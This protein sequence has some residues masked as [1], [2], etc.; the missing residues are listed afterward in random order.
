MRQW[1]WVTV[2]L[3]LV[4][5][6][7]HTE[8]K[9]SQLVEQARA[10]AKSWQRDAILVEI[11]AT[12]GADG[13]LDLKAKGLPAHSATF[14]FFSPSTEQG[15]LVTFV[16][17]N[18]DSR[19]FPAGQYRLPIPDA[20]IDLSQ[21]VAGARK[22]GFHE[23]SMFG[24]SSVAADLTVHQTES[25]NRLAW[26]LGGSDQAGSA[27]QMW[28]DAGSGVVFTSYD[29]L[30]SGVSSAEAERRKAQ[31]E[32]RLLPQNTAGDFVSLRKE[33]DASATAQHPNFRLYQV[34]LD[35]GPPPL[36]RVKE[37]D[38]HY[39]REI[40]PLGMGTAASPPGWEELEVHVIHAYE[41]WRISGGRGEQ[42]LDRGTPPTPVPANILSPEEAFRRLKRGLV[43]PYTEGQAPTGPTDL[44]IQLIQGV[45]TYFI[46]RLIGPRSGVTEKED[47]RFFKDTD[48][49]GKWTWWTVAQHVGLPGARYEYLYLD[50][51]TGQ[52][53]SHCAEAQAEPDGYLLVE[54]PCAPPR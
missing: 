2:L 39:F 20:F 18:L 6:T 35:M 15:F 45:P 26:H 48:P 21:A 4:S 10:K 24:G 52:A 22:S 8:D 13:T 34:E 1:S 17:G 16:A 31:L 32:E 14:S 36:Y 29:E 51:V 47:G 12:A 33:A 42:F 23:S 19:P 11:R 37:G 7:A 53:T 49:Q 5:C 43:A 54:V 40:P 25:G 27:L 28:V 41:G 30:T 46:R 50:A 3:L 44:S 38:F 9:I